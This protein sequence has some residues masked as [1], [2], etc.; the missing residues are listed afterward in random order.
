MVEPTEFEPAAPFTPMKHNIRIVLA[1]PVAFFAL[2]FKALRPKKP[3][4]CL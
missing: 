3:V 4:L 1:D 2:F